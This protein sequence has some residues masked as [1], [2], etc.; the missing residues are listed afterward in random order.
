M[1]FNMTIF[2]KVHGQALA[3]AVLNAEKVLLSISRSIG[4]WERVSCN[5]SE[6]YFNSVMFIYTH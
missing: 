1:E 6:K 5:A 3:H 2:R 4:I